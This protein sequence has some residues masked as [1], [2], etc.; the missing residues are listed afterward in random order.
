MAYK[1]Q[2]SKLYGAAIKHLLKQKSLSQRQF[3]G[4]AKLTTDYVSK[5][6]NGKV[7]E[8]RQEQR[9]K[10]AK[11]L[12]V[13]EA[14]LQKLVDD[15]IGN[16]VNFNTSITTDVSGAVTPTI[17][18]ANN[19]H[20]Y[21]NLT[22]PDYTA[23][24]GRKEE[25]S[26]LLKYLSPDNP[27]HV[28]TIYGI[29]GVG[30]TALIQRAA[31]LCLEASKGVV[32][33]SGVPEFDAIIFTSAKNRRLTADG[34]LGI[35]RAQRNLS[36]I[37]RE[38]AITLERPAITQATAENQLEIVRESL[39]N[40]R[41]LLIVDNME[42]IE[43]TDSILD[44]LIDLPLGVKAVITTRDRRTHNHIRLECLSSGEGIQLI[45]HQASERRITLSEDDC[46][47]IYNATEGIPIA[48]VYAIGRIASGYSVQTVLNRIA[49]GTG[50]VA[51]FLFK[52]CVQEMRGNPEHKLLMSLAIFPYSAVRDA[53][54]EVAGLIADRIDPEDGLVTLLDLCLIQ[55][56]DARYS[57]L[58]L[59]REY[60]LLE[61]AACPDFHQE[62]RER[63]V[64]WYHNFL[65]KYG[66]QYWPERENKRDW[67][68]QYEGLQVEWETILEVLEWCKR[69]KRYADIRDF[70]QMLHDFAFIYG[71][72]TERSEWIDWLI[73]ASQVQRDW[74]TTVEALNHQGFI[75]IC[76]DGNE[77]LQKAEQFFNRAWE[78]RNYADLRVQIDL[79]GHIALMKVKQQKYAEAE[80][81]QAERKKTI[82]CLEESKRINYILDFYCDQ[83]EI[84]I[85]QGKYEEAKIICQKII[86]ESEEIGYYSFINEAQRCLANIGILQGDLD[87]VENL[88]N[89]GLFVANRNKDKRK[90][91]LYQVS[92]ARLEKAKINSEKSREWANKALD[93]FKRLGMIK[94]AKEVQNL[95]AELDEGNQ[96]TRD[97]R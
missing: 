56:K 25:L 15:Y 8:P 84:Y 62:A 73:E 64:K 71:Y 51:H 22:S 41:P 48:I 35:Q 32:P 24:I 66:W 53:V 59:T 29:G 12:G 65:Q 40:Q 70:W 72:W 13:T 97:K 54:A 44:F 47:N 80:Q 67:Y 89:D 3:A 31:F 86:K 61:L 9:R 68:I 42:T 1:P 81:W 93:G 52:D 79:A 74:Q 28:I 92:F 39:R 50:D 96:A 75:L 30:K 11:G 26:R 60:A 10:I 82:D 20:I 43:G 5:L 94:D 83:K 27:N 87:E 2:N 45:K 58:P 90:I 16:Y 14:E 77:N 76:Q 36:D 78:M 37:F 4:K 63:W 46:I 57:M 49:S 23:F 33:V 34:M 69:Q 18:V 21:H 38:I 55:R 85:G 6:V 17:F 91:A 7:A 88:L 95:L 19:R